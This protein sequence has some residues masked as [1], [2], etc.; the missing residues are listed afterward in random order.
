M[1]TL[2]CSTFMRLVRN[3][4]IITFVV[5][6]ICVRLNQWSFPTILSFFK[7]LNLVLSLLT[8]SNLSLY[9][10]F[11]SVG[12]LFSKLFLLHIDIHSFSSISLPI[13][14]K[15]SSHFPP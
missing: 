15:H 3:W 6:K 5:S 14:P 4:F 2:P 9:S 7:V 10:Y 12:R 8:Y 13:Q 1:I 11:P